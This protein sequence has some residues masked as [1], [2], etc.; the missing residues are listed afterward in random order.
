MGIGA[1]VGGLDAEAGFQAATYGVGETAFRI[2]AEEQDRQRQDPPDQAQYRPR[3]EAVLGQGD[4]DIGV[5]VDLGS[6]Q[7]HVGDGHL[8]RRRDARVVRNVVGDRRLVGD[9][10]DG[11]RPCGPGR[12]GDQ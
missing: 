6:R 7:R 3:Q 12:G 1:D 5:L 8:A 4:V 11:G 10:A 9:G 2:N